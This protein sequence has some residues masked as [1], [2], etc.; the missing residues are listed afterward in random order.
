M[1]ATS[2]DT[3]EITAKAPVEPSPQAKSI[4]SI[5]TGLGYA[6]SATSRNVINVADNIDGNKFNIVVLVSEDGSEV[7]INCQV[8][9]LNQIPDDQIAVQRDFFFTLV[10]M[11]DVISPF[12]T[13]IVTP[14]DDASVSDGAHVTLV[15]RFNIDS[16]LSDDLAYQM[17]SLRKAV[18]TYN[19][20]VSHIFA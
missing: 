14:E 7:S 17:N 10:N 2:S 9:N 6:T 11:N 16:D 19:S 8:G 12:A 4:A 3:V 13:S 5:L 1:G 18:I 15:N 20:Q